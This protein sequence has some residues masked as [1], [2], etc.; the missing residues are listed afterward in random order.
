MEVA[1]SCK[2]ARCCEPTCL[3]MDTT[4]KGVGSWKPDRCC[5]TN[6]RTHGCAKQQTSPWIPL[7]YISGREEKNNA[8]VSES[9]FVFRNSEVSVSLIR[10]KSVTVEEMVEDSRS[11]VRMERVLDSH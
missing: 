2:T 1:D 6:R 11:P 7:D 10:T 4:M 5:G 9:S 8:F 3:S